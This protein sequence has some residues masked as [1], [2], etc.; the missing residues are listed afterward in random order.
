VTAQVLA[1]PPNPSGLCQCGCG[2]ETRVVPYHYEDGF[3][4]RNVHRRFVLGHHARGRKFPN[5]VRGPEHPLWKGG[6]NR[7]ANGYML[8]NVPVDHPFAAMAQKHPT[9]LRIYEHRL[10]MAEYLG[11]PLARHE[12]VHHVNGVRDDNRIENLQ[13]RIGSHGPGQAHVCLDCGS[14]RIAPVGITESE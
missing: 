3:S 2:E 14:T 9:S 5:A 1:L 7:D 13:L 8:I 4:F 10:V 6:R 11:R 12:T